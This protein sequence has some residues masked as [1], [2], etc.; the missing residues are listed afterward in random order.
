MVQYFQWFI[1]LNGVDGGLEYE[2]YANMGLATITYDMA[3]DTL[4]PSIFTS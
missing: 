4:G 2:F 3:S 1:L